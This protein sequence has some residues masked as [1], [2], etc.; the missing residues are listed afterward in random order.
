MMQETIRKVSWVHIENRKLLC[1]RSRG[2]D[3]FYNPGGKP[4]VGESD[5]AA[6]I[7]ELKEELSIDVRPETIKH[8]HTIHAEA[9]GKNAGKM[10]ELKCFSA[11]YTGTM[12]PA[13]EIEEIGYIDSRLQLPTSAS[14]RELIQWLHER[15]LID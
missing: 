7:R 13:H 2:N 14:G 4:E 8:V 1:V 15:D 9:H 6:F 10:L 11:E 12:T 5:E 3:T